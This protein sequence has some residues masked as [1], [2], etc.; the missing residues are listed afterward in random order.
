LYQLELMP[1]TAALPGIVT[2]DARSEA[3][4]EPIPN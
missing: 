3:V 2:A 1:R 4:V